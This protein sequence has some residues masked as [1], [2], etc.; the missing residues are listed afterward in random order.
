MGLYLV[1]HRRA[2]FERFW[3]YITRHIKIAWKSV[4]FNFKQYCCFFAAIFIIQMLY[5]MMAIS[6]TNNN[7]VAYQQI[8]EQY[9]FT[10]DCLVVELTEDSYA[11]DR[12]A[13]LRTIEGLHAM[14]LRIVLDDIGAGYSSLSD[15]STYPIE[16]KKQIPYRSLHRRQ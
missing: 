6:A 13:A 11:H 9:D 7:S 15:L 14:G 4:F 8:V 1:R 3:E 16:R 10:R 12:E 2:M 5:G